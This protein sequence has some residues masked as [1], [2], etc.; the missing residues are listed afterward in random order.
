MLVVTLTLFSSSLCM[1]EREKGLKD[2]KIENLGE[3][4]DLKFIENTNLVY[5]IS[6]T[7]LLTLFDTENQKISWK[8]QLPQLSNNE[9]YQLKY[10]SRN[11]IVFSKSR[12]L[13]VN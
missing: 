10:L 8:K 4:V 12:A 9:L 5:T 7:G 13:M 3:I 6:T 2:W 11:L 1:Y